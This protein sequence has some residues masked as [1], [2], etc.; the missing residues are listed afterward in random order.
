MSFLATI[1]WCQLSC[2]AVSMYDAEHD[3]LL[4][5]LPIPWRSKSELNREG[6]FLLWLVLHHKLFLRPLIPALRGK[7]SGLRQILEMGKSLTDYLVLDSTPQTN[8]VGV[9]YPSLALA[10]ALLLLVKLTSSFHYNAGHTYTM[11][12]LVK[13]VTLKN[14]SNE[15]H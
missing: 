2:F 9:G 6:V 12:E 10:L 4:H 14:H 13:E 7:K 3:V 11:Q 8:W 15:R 5:I 1:I